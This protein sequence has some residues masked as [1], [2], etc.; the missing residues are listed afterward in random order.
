MTKKKLVILVAP[1]GGNAMDREGA[2]VPLTPEEIAEEGVRCLEAGAS[3][4]HML[5]RLIGDD[6]FFR[7]IR[8]YYAENRFKKAGTDDLRKAMEAESGRTLERFF[9][10]WIYDSTIPQLRFSSTQVG[11]ELAVRFEQAGEVFD[12]PV[13]VT[14]T[15]MDGKTSEHLVALSEAVTEQRLPL[16]GTVR[17][18]EVNQDGGAVAV[19]ERR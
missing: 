13:L 14:V 18:V 7:G 10:R 16:T 1:T 9:E 2:H 8:R 17:S 5:R 11:Q 4:L 3:V 15:Y 19:I 6:A 12:L